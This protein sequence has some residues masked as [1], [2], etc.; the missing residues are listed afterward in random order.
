MESKKICLGEHFTSYDDLKEK[1]KKYEEE[2][3]V[4]LWIRDSRTNEA[5]RVKKIYNPAIKFYEIGYAY[6]H[7]GRKFKSE[8]T[9]VR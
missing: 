5:V 6:N 3:F 1:M 9:R 4:S 7:S 2:N 8:S